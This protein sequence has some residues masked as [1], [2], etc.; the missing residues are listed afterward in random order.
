M[1]IYITIHFYYVY[2]LKNPK[3]YYKENFFFNSIFLMD[4]ELLLLEINYLQ[5]E[6]IIKLLRSMCFCLTE[7]MKTSH[8]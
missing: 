7:K 2:V 8:I 6:L 4:I 1:F 5:P 3:L